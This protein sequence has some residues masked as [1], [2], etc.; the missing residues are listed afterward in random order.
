VS[1]ANRQKQEKQRR[2]AAIMGG[3]I[4]VIKKPWSVPGFAENVVCPRLIR[5]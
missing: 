2:R 1:K 4:A 3:R 5:A